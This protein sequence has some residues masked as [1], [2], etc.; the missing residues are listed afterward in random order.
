[1]PR[2]VDPLD[3][4]HDGVTLRVLVDCDEAAQREGCRFWQCGARKMF[5]TPSQRAAVSAHWSAQLRA[6]VAATADRD[7]NRVLVDLQDE[8]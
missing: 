1:M 5:P 7:R 3:V 8:P 2:P 4:L 6:K